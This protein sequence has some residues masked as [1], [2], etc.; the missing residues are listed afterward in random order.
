MRAKLLLTSFLP[1]SLLF[2][3]TESWNV[4]ANGSWD[5]A[6]NWNPATVPNAVNEVARLGNPVLSASRTVALCCQS[7]TVGTLLLTSTNAFGYQVDAIN[8]H[9]LNIVGISPSINIP[10]ANQADHSITAP[11]S[12]QGILLLEQESSNILTIS[13]GITGNNNLECV[14]NGTGSILLQGVNN[15]PTLFVSNGTLR[16]GSSNTLPAGSTLQMFPLGTLDLNSFNQSIGTLFGSGGSITLGNATLSIS[17]GADH[18]F[19][20]VISGAGS[21]VFNG[22]GHTWTLKDGQTYTGGTTIN[23]GTIALGFNNDL[24]VGRDVTLT[25][26][27]ILDLIGFNQTIGA[28]S[29][30][31]GAQVNLGSG[32]LTVTPTTNSTF[33]GTISGTGRLVAAG[34]GALYLSNSNNTY[35]GGTTI[36][37]G[38]IQISAPGALGNSASSVTLG[39]GTLE[40]LP[41]FGSQTLT[42]NILLNAPG[43]TIQVDAG[44][45]PNYQGN[46]TGTGPLNKT[47]AGV[48]MLSGTGNF[49]GGTTI[50][51]G[52][53]CLMGG[54]LAGAVNI[55]PGSILSGAGSIGSVINDGTVMP[56]GS[57]NVTGSYVQNAAGVFAANLS[58]I[59]AT[60]LLTAATATLN[61]TLNVSAAPGA[62][63]AGKQYTILTAAGGVTPLFTTVNF[64]SF[65]NMAITYEPDAVLLTV[66]SQ[67][68]LP[69]ATVKHYNPNQVLNY[70]QKIQH[71]IDSDLLQIVDS[72]SVLDTDQ[73][74]AALDQLHPAPFGAFDLLNSSTSSQIISL[75]SRHLGRSCCIH[76]TAEQPP[77]NCGCASTSFWIQPFG[78]VY[79]QDKIGEQFGFSSTT[80]GFAAGAGYR[81][82]EK[83]QVGIGAGYS[84][85]H[86]HWDHGHG[87]GT[88]E[89]RYL[90]V[91]TDYTR[92]TFYIE[93]SAFGGIDT[94]FASRHIDFTTVNTRARH[95]GGGY[96]FT[97]HLGLGGD[98]Q[99]SKCYL[100]PFVSVD[101]F[102]LFQKKFTEHGAG[103]LNL[104]VPGRRSKILRSKVGLSATE[105][106]PI[107]DNSCWSPTVWISGISEI[108][109]SSPLYHARFVNESLHF[110]ARTFHKPIYLIAPGIDISFLLKKRFGFSIRYE[111][112]LNSEI[113]DQKMDARLEWFF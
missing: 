25:A 57:M 73:L 7:P 84:S 79:N 56:I 49:T 47:G 101:Y 50:T 18:D 17:Q 43:G 6:S 102:Y 42:N 46:I 26:T 31:V 88:T 105:S 4:D 51:G 100:N 48:F 83:V 2:A 89:T 77:S 62:Y 12:Y 99:L 70:L 55:A 64:P 28:L 97:A 8:G 37:S 58:G 53:I 94:F 78:N 33:A 20:G 35:S 41:L 61:G 10:I 90:G 103:E 71:D 86:L 110:K 32:T 40:L 22:N 68:I 104:V 24:P 93:A 27:G 111:A 14:G 45:Q 95:H 1:F 11:L 19:E 59:Q 106:Y 69:L 16:L 112:E 29:G 108:Y 91:Y 13:G 96:N 15:F 23:N 76:P 80:S 44:A 36:N 67:S 98:I 52:T 65:L 75:F 9:Q 30:S 5:V 66:I 85:S 82:P 81:F 34:S 38:T 63:A 87:K 39:G 113:A 72:L 107:G 109:L 92:D 3:A 54:S 74:T 21:L 60:G